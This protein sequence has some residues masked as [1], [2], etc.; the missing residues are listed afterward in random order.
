MTA[1][2]RKLFLGGLTKTTTTDQL[3]EIFGQF[4]TVVDAVVM[5]RN[6]NPRGFGFVTFKDKS[7]LDAVLKDGVTIDGR[8]VDIKRAVPEE[9]MAVASSKVFVGGLPQTVDKQALQEHFETFG[10]VR[11]AVVMVDRT[12]GRSRGFG[13]VRFNS[14][15]AVERVIATPQELGGHPVDVKRAEPADT[16]PP[17]PPA[18]AKEDAKSRRR[19]RGK[20]ADEDCLGGADPAAAAAFGLDPQAAAAAAAQLNLAMSFL[21]L[22]QQAM[23]GNQ[24]LPPSFPPNLTQAASFFAATAQAQANAAMAAS[25]ANGAAE[26]NAHPDLTPMQF[27]AFEKP[28]ESAGLPLG[29][30]SNV[31]NGLNGQRPNSSSEKAR[32]GPPLPVAKLGHAP[33]LGMPDSALAAKSI[34]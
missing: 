30:L 17:A 28:R 5:E 15:D 10:E 26:L 20:R 31:L 4:G 3:F 8:E 13:F 9:E 23:M 11:D 32:W 33:G 21:S 29:D 2:G 19:R 12:T 7:S 16:M 14:P 22:T 27:D 1:N 24:G 6:G 34:W 25:V 18:R